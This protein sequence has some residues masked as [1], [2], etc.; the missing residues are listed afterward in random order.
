MK[1]FAEKV[2]NAN[3]ELN[4]KGQMKQNVRNGLK[5]DVLQAMFEMFQEAGLDAYR[6]NDG[7]AVNFENA[8]LGSVAI[9][10]DG[11]VKGLEYDAMDEAELYENALK[12]KA[13]K[14]LK[15]EQAKQA[16]IAEK[17]L[18]KAKMAEKKVKAVK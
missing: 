13:E 4:E 3:Y 9:V 16:R 1:Q 17:E 18:L 7:V 11:V 8:E 15:A 12:E 14:A 2:L 5:A 6:V 10:F